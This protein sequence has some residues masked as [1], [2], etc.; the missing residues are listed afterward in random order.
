MYFVFVSTGLAGLT[1]QGF[2]CNYYSSKPDIIHISL[3][4]F[5]AGDSD[6]ITQHIMILLTTQP[7]PDYMDGTLTFS[8]FPCSNPHT[9][10]SLNSLNLFRCKMAY[11]YF[12]KTYFVTSSTSSLQTTV[13]FHFRHICILYT[14]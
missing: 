11:L 6:P 2:R 9:K 3:R 5:G 4:A 7:S 1:G 8:H 12:K 10:I 13:H 14:A